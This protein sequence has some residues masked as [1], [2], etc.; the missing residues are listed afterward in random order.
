MLRLLTNAG[1]AVNVMEFTCK[2]RERGEGLKGAGE[3]GGDHEESVLERVEEEKVFF[4]PK[5]KQKGVKTIKEQHYRPKN[6]QYLPTTLFF[7]GF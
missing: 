4:I 6:H 2:K 5:L 1:I 7:S 3:G